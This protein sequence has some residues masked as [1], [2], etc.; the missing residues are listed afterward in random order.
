MADAAVPP[1]SSPVPAPKPAPALEPT[2]LPLCTSAELV[3]R[4]R[5]VVWDVLLWGRPARAFALRFDGVVVAYLNR[6]VHVPTEMDWQEGEF[7]DLDKRWI[8][9]SIHGAAYEPADG[10]CVGGPCGRG[11][12]TPIAVAERGGQVYWYPSQDIAPVRFDDVP[13]AA[14]PA[15]A[16]EPKS[17]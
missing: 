4:G 5:A 1:A 8:L 7:L 16:P 10:R 13:A 11:K 6:C 3:E 9:C 14:S 2:E 17:A 15:T 12:L